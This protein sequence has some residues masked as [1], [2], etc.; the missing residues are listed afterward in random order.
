MIRILHMLYGMNIGGAET[1]V[2][3]ILSC[4]DDKK[5][6]LDIAIQ[7]NN[8][9]NEKLNTLCQNKN[10]QVH[11]LPRF[12]KNYF[13][14]LRAV[15]NLIKNSDYDIIHIHMNALIN[16][17]PIFIALF[18]GKKVI[19]HSHSTQNNLGGK[20]GEL[21]HKTNKLLLNKLNVERVACGKDAGLWMFGKYSFIVLD[22]A[23]SISEFK[24]D[25]NER[26]SIW[27]ELGLS[28][29]KVIGHVGRFV[30]VKNH[31]FLLEVFS[32]YTKN[33]QNVAL[34]MVGDGELMETMRLRAKEL[35][36]ENKVYFVGSRADVRRYYSSFDCLLFPSKF[37]GLPFVLVEAQTN[38][39]PV[40][41]SD[42]VTREM[43][44]VGNMYFVPLEASMQ[45][46]IE[47]IE[48]AL[49]PVDRM[50][51]AMDMAETKYNITNMVKK[52]EDL[53]CGIINI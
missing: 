2:Y 47:M 30:E 24:Y 49:E 19:I 52:V 42:K 11:M 38:G 14:Y 8:I 39:L 40:V 45:V 4:I 37:E 21:L 10:C 18:F 41:A 5:F 23:I 3:N 31:E 25:E 16:V 22:N 32:E 48:K 12:N 15:K 27:A 33:H 28:G 29:K 7:D 51:Y 36:L 6:Q 26:N 44:L 34:V 1:F 46:W 53:Y 13:A 43:D 17:A 50:K 9:T 20:P 35:S